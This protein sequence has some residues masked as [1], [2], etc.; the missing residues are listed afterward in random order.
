MGK[1]LK[2]ENMERA[3]ARERMF[4]ACLIIGEVPGGEGFWA[5]G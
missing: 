4:R 1:I 2:A 3:S 5:A